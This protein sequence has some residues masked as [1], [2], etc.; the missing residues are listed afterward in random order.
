M[1]MSYTITV[2]YAPSQA[3][4]AVVQEGLI[5][6]YE[7]LMG[8]SRDKEFSIFIKNATGEI[9]GGMQAHFDTESVYI[10][11]LWVAEQLRK[12]GF[13]KKMLDAAEQEAVKNG[14]K[15]STLDTWSFQAEAFYV[16]N[17]YE[18]IGEI[19]NYWHEHSR[20]FLRKKIKV[21]Y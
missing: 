10:E 14:C 12:Q 9:V 16:K 17:G 5:L 3:D 2:D 20:I 6:S 21:N 19:K 4:N 11:M 8:E 7:L 18:R 1:V 13:G 15:Y